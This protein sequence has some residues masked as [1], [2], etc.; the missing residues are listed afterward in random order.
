MKMKKAIQYEYCMIGMN[1]CGLIANLYE[2][3]GYPYKATN[4][5]IRGIAFGYRCL[6]KYL[7]N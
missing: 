1:I 6:K 5:R 3:L 2:D 7:N 4:W